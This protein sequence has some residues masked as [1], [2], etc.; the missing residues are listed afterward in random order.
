M[1]VFRT[2]SVPTRL[3]K[4]WGILPI[5]SVV[6]VVHNSRWVRLTEL[7]LRRSFLRPITASLRLFLPYVRYASEFGCI[8][9]S[10]WGG[11]GAL[12]SYSGVLSLRGKEGAPEL[13]IWEPLTGLKTS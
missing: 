10:A 2:P 12:V 1:L 9:N 13:Q 7:H 6:F 4:L 8:L 11:G 5:H 3:G